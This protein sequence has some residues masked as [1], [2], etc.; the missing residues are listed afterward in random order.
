MAEATTVDLKGACV[1]ARLLNPD[2]CSGLVR[3]VAKM[4]GVPMPDV[5]ANH[6]VDYFEDPANGWEVVDESTAQSSADANRLVVAGK[7]NVG[8]SGHVVVVFPGGKKASGGYE[9]FYKPL[10]KN[11]TMKNDGDFPRMCGTGKSD[12]PGVESEGEKTVY[13]AWASATKYADVKYWR[14]PSKK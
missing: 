8:S 3:H 1:E 4:M 11:L 6:L 9:Y 10:K 7:K 14:A 5:D 12:W 2:N 13:D